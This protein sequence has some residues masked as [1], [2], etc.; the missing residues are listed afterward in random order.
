MRST[1]PE[2]RD[3]AQLLAEA[4]RALLR[5][6]EAGEDGRLE[7]LLAVFS[8]LAADPE[9][10]A[11]LILTEWLFRA[12]RGELLNADAWLARFPRCTAALRRRLALPD[13]DHTP[14]ASTAPASGRA[15]TLPHAQAAHHDGRC[16]DALEGLEE[17]G[18][19]AMGVVYRAR[20]PALGGPVALKVLRSGAGASAAEVARF[21][22][23]ARAAAQIDHPHVVRVLD[24]GRHL[25]LPAFT[26]ALASGGNLADRRGD[27]AAVAAAV[28][29]VEKLARGVAAAHAAGIVHR[30]L[31]PSNV[32]FDERG[33]PVVSD[34]GLARFVRSVTELTLPGQLIGTPAY[35]APEQ[36]GLRPPDVSPASDVWSLGVLLYELL[37]GRK[38][39]DGSDLPAMLMQVLTVEPPAL[40]SL[41][42]QVDAGLEAI[43]RKCLDK[44]PRQRYTHAGELADALEGWRSGAGGPP[45]QRRARRYRLVALALL[46]VGLGTA[47]LFALGVGPAPRPVESAAASDLDSRLERGETI[48]LIGADEPAVPLRWLSPGLVARATED[49]TFTVQT[50]GLALVQLAELRRAR[51]FRLCAEVR[52]TESAGGSRV[53]L[54]FRAVAP[55][56]ARGQ[57]L[58]YCDLSLDDHDPAFRDVGLKLRRYQPQRGGVDINGGPLYQP[59]PPP[60]LKRAWYD[61]ELI[62]APDGV[63]ARLNGQPLQVFPLARWQAYETALF[64][65]LPVPVGDLPPYPNGGLGLT[66]YRGGASVKNCV[67]RPLGPA[68]RER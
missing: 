38:P 61:L 40:R 11:D 56:T 17:I 8:A 9:R 39:F 5:R 20:D 53:G 25:G 48:A 34:F 46:V 64:Q 41:R 45:A 35:L 27:F 22:R 55:V 18:R 1:Q 2:L 13:A 63:T 33:E 21:V 26:M 4:R 30:D 3:P 16:L 28:R 10:A 37:A 31:K 51:G 43:V 66:V 67:L 50:L 29:L 42:P 52:H 44:D 7:D 47:A 15:E 12:S 59:L 58:F 57:E 19:G 14:E 32:L 65:P 23:E 49:N 36:T 24:V 60:A 54:F 68:A 6:L 62:V